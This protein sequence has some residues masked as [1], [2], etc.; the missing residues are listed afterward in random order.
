[1]ARKRKP[2]S[3]APQLPLKEAL[4]QLHQ[5]FDIAFDEAQALSHAQ[6]PGRNHLLTD[7][8][9]LKRD[10]ARA[11]THYNLRQISQKKRR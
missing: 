8:Y 3:Q 7:I 2:H 11:E 4:D 9:K 1:M 6:L 10:L 5:W